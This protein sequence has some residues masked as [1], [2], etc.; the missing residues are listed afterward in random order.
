MAAV[1]EQCRLGTCHRRR[2]RII[3]KQAQAGHYHAEGRPALVLVIVQ[4][5]KVVG[6]VHPADA[7]RRLHHIAHSSEH[8]RPVCTHGE[9]QTAHVATVNKGQLRQKLRRP[10][11]VPRYPRAETA[12]HLQHITRQRL[13]RII[14]HTLSSATVAPE[15]RVGRQHHIAP[16][17]QLIAHVDI[18]IAAVHP[19][20]SV[21]HNGAIHV[22]R[23]HH[24]LL[25][26]GEMSTVVVQ[27]QQRRRLLLCRKQHVGHQQIGRSALP[28]VDVERNLLCHITVTLLCGHHLIRPLLRCRRLHLHGPSHLLA[29]LGAP[30]LKRH[31]SATALPRPRPREAFLHLLIKHRHVFLRAPQLGHGVLRHYLC[32]ENE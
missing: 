13:L 17:C 32:A 5:H 27:H 29:G 18:V 11:V 30:L 1:K 26:N 8:P 28:R 6:V 9:A 24:L 3:L 16:P 19:V 21:G 10:H 22:K 20:V 15:Q 7:C 14:A 4:R 23:P 25:A 12:T 2:V 31:R